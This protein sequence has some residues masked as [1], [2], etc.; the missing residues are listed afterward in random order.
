M[1]YTEVR[2]LSPQR[3]GERRGPQRIFEF[4]P[5]ISSYT[6]SSAKSI[7]MKLGK[8]IAI[9]PSHIATVFKKISALLGVLCGSAV[10][11]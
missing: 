11:L 3:R 1:K 10:S 6:T 5:G 7:N 8:P 4:P 2:D 9:H